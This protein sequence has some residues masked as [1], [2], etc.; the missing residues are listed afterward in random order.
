MDSTECIRISAL[1]AV[2]LE[3]ARTAATEE[4][5]RLHPF[6]RGESLSRYEVIESQ[7]SH[8]L[9]ASAVRSPED[10]L[11]RFAGIADAAGRAST[12][13]EAMRLQA[14]QRRLVIVMGSFIDQFAVRRGWTDLWADH[15]PLD[16]MEATSDLVLQGVCAYAAYIEELAWLGEIE[17]TQERGGDLGWDAVEQ[18]EVIAER[19][20]LAW[21]SL[22]NGLSAALTSS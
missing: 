19:I 8:V 21:H 13:E 1:T 20:K 10:A 3:L 22:G 17:Y 7:L 16:L 4:L 11:V 12:V 14:Q 5:A 15:Y 6:D 2:E 9:A 18:H